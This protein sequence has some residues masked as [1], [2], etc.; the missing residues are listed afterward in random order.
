MDTWYISPKRISDLEAEAAA[1]LGTPFREN[2]AVRGLGGG[3]SCHNLVAELYFATGCLERFVVPTGSA[4]SLRHGP[5]NAML[6]YLDAQLAGRFAAVPDASPEKIMPG[7]MLAISD[8]RNVLHVGVAL[9][10]GRFV[11]VLKGTG[12]MVSMLRDST[13]KITAA[14]RPLP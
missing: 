12:V 11:H 10:G 3:V 13:Y 2:S 5:A 1:W 14:R 8:G 7:D 9:L 4:R 6:D